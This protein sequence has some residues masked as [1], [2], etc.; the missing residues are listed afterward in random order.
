MKNIHFDLIDSTN[1]YLKREYT[2]LDSFTFVDASFQTSGKG[3]EDRKWISNNNEN[4]LFSFLIK[5]KILLQ[6]FKKL[7][8]GI[9]IIISK[10][11]E[12]L[13]LSPTI[14]WPNDIFVGDKKICGILLEGNINEYVA[15]GVGLNVNQN[16]FPNDLHHPATSMRIESK[17]E[18]SISELK[19][20]L[21]IY[22]EKMIKN[23]NQ[24][25]VQDYLLTHNYLLNK[26]VMINNVI[27]I[28]SGISFDN[29]LEITIDKKKLLFDS[30]EV[31]IL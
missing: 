31:N 5:D 1:A 18:F 16:E 22:I 2:S 14:K 24:I 27:G 7:S 28:V 6:S 26:K 12:T 20:Q 29:R 10:Y 15:I 3:R 19:N 8:I 21:F 25:D 4:L 11:L 13:G 17:K 30:G 9:A 23:L